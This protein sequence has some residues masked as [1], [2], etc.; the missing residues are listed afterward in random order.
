VLR[1]FLVR[2]F[3]CRRAGSRGRQTTRP[4]DTT[5]TRPF[6]N[7]RQTIPSP[8]HRDGLL[9]ARENGVRRKARIPDRRSRSADPSTRIGD[10]RRQQPRRHRDL[11]DSGR[12][13]AGAS[14]QDRSLY[15]GL[16][17]RAAFRAKNHAGSDHQSGAPAESAKFDIARAVVTQALT[18]PVT[19]QCRPARCGHESS[20]YYNPATGHQPDSSRSYAT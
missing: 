3:L 8:L 17:R 11:Y 16:R 2:R 18:R 5:G 19:C 6:F 13:R 10:S 1:L 14:A 20:P 9:P 4:P 15:R 7:Q 12:W